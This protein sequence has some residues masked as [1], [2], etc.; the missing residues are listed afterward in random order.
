ME[1]DKT[2]V[3]NDDQNFFG[4]L[5]LIQG[6]VTRMAGNSALMKGFAATLIAAMLGMSIVETIKWYY[7]AI[8]VIP[9]I[10][11]IRLD[12]YYLQLERRYRNLYKL[13]ASN[14][15]LVYVVRC[16]LDLKSPDLEKYKEEIK[17]NSGFFKTAFSASI[18]QFYVWFIILAFGLII[19][20]A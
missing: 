11:F 1:S 6:V 20:V 15:D 14:Q 13:I 16:T 4:Y 12:I 17:K 10:A 5:S 8:A 18:W 7:I 9:L 3:R 2:L 19:F